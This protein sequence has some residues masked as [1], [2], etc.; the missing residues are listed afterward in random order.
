M[1]FV[2]V[3]VE[4]AFVFDVGAFVFAA[5]VFVFTAAVFVFTAAAFAFVVGAAVPA[6]VT[7]VFV[8]F[9]SCACAA[10]TSVESIFAAGSLPSLTNVRMG[11]QS[12]ARVEV[13]SAEC[14]FRQWRTSDV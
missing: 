8:A 12:H 11:A 1:V 10:Q 5:G 4:G 6:G 14:P 9:A 3:L 2:F 13:R 7:V